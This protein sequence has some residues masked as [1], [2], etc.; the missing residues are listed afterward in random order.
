MAGCLTG[1]NPRCLG[2]LRSGQLSFSNRANKPKRERGIVFYR[3]KISRAAGWD[4]S[5]RTSLKKASRT[6]LVV[7][8]ALDRQGKL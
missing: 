4:S 5:I 1:V 8:V 7:L 2:Q 3:K 6:A